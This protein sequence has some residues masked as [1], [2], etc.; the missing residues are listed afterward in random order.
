MKKTHL[1]VAL[2]F[3]ASSLSAQNIE[4]QLFNL[5]DIIFE[6][7]LTPVGYEGAYELK[8]RQ[9]LDHKD[10]SKGYFY[11]RVFKSRRF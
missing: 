4:E 1:F 10:P 9:P 6:K 2:L 3:I 11:Q 5:P 8:V 7:V